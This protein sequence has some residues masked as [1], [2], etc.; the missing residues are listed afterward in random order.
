MTDGAKHKTW[1]REVAL[2]NFL[3]TVGFFGWASWSNNQV[4]LSSAQT[5]LPFTAAMLAM[6]YGLHGW[7]QYV[8]ETAA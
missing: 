5:L 1:K 3:I 2:V 6:A 7:K 4:A 8:K